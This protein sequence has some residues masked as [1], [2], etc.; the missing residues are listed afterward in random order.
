MLRRAPSS[1][2]PKI[3]TGGSSEDVDVS[4]ELDELSSPDGD[5]LVQAV[6]IA[7]ASAARHAR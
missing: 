5:A 2:D 1:V 6:T 3:A 4:P 7:I